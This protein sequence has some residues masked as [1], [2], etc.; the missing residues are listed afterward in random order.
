MDYNYEKALGTVVIII[1]ESLLLK[2]SVFIVHVLQGAVWFNLGTSI[3]YKRLG[4]L[5][6]ILQLRTLRRMTPPADVELYKN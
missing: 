3:Y 5:K 1:L 2:S 4:W 6:F